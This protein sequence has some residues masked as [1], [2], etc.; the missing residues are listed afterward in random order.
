MVLCF[1]CPGIIREWEEFNLKTC[2]NCQEEEEWDRKDENFLA[3]ITGSLLANR[4]QGQV[5]AAFHCRTRKNVSIERRSLK[6][7]HL[8]YIVSSGGKGIIL[9]GLTSLSLQTSVK[10]KIVLKT[11]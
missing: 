4:E 1:G 6:E 11:L 7:L 3:Q 9:P 10:G 8:Y 5:K 2:D